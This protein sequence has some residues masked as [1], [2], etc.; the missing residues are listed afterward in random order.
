MEELKS[1]YR[2]RSF[3]NYSRDALL[4]EQL[5]ASCSTTFNDPYDTA[6]FY[7]TERIAKD[8][9]NWSDEDKEK[10]GRFLQ[11]QQC[12]R[13]DGSDVFDGKHI[14]D[15]F[16]RIE[17][18][19][20]WYVT[21][22]LQ[23]K[24]LIVCLSQSFKDEMMWAHYANNGTGFVLKYNS[25][26][27]VDVFD[28][29]L[30]NTKDKI[31][32]DSE[33]S[34]ALEEKNH[35]FG[36]NT[37]EYTN[38]HANGTE[39]YENLIRSGNDAFHSLTSDQISNFLAS[40]TARRMVL[41]KSKCWSKEK[42]YRI[43]LPNVN[44][45][46]YENIGNIVP[47]AIYLGEKVSHSDRYFAMCYCKTKNIPLYRMKRNLNTKEQGLKAVKYPKEYIEDIVNNPKAIGTIEVY[48][49]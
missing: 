13:S 44:N 23:S 24:F 36:I 39:L 29:Y 1:Y 22:P 19:G 3:S 5:W 45:K 12:Q 46:N 42:E 32:K 40:D 2:Y 11:K 18:F 43:V 28:S 41:T 47:T 26:D 10:A 9:I 48:Q 34:S 25:M 4:Q 37:V 21:T 16:H 49:F 33:F 20:D 17:K 8:I 31:V 15:L 35:L 30:N 6:L 38:N 27:I 7:D 14:N